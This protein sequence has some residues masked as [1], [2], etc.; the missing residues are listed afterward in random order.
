MR[1]VTVLTS[2]SKTYYLTCPL[3][4]IGVHWAEKKMC[5][6]GLPTENVNNGE[7]KKWPSTY[8]QTV[9]KR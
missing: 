9:L 6:K 4:G 3:F 8:Q 1:Y 2:S 7:G 5:A